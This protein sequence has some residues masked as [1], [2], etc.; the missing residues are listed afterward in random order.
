MMRQHKPDSKQQRQWTPRDL[1]VLTLLGQQ[2]AL[3]LDHV[4]RFLALFEGKAGVEQ[5]VN[6][7][8]ATHNL[9]EHLQH[10]GLIQL[11]QFG[12]NKSNWIWLT[13]EGMQVA[14]LSSAAKKRPARRI[15]PAL[16]AT[17]TVRLHLAEQ[18]P[19]SSWVS[20]QQLRSSDTAR[21]PHLTP[22]AVLETGRGERI[23]IHIMLRLTRTEEQIADHML[24]Q[25][26]QERDLEK[27]SYSALW[28]YAP[29]DV[30]KKLRAARASIAKSTTRETA[31][32]ICIFTYPLVR[33][34]VLYRGHKAPV[35]ALAWS[36]D[37]KWLASAGED[38]MLNVWDAVTGKERFH[39]TLPVNP[40]A[41]GWSC[42][43]AWIALGDKDGR[44]SFWEGTTGK[45][46]TVEIDDPLWIIGLA[47]S[48]LHNDVIASC[49]EQGILLMYDLRQNA[50][51]WK[52]H[53]YS[54]LK[55][56]AWSPDGTRLAI[57]GNDTCVR[58][59]DA[60]TGKHLQTYKKHNA[61][62]QALVW[63]PDSQ[64]IAST[65]HEPAI[66]IWDA[67]SGKRRRTIRSGLNTISVLAW[68]PDGTRLACAGSEPYVQ[69]WDIATGRLLMTY[70]DHSDEITALAW[71]PDSTMLASASS[72][73]TV[74]VY[75]VESS[76]R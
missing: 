32:N 13:K 59:I 51:Q 8:S 40:S 67:V 11:Q 68:S 61:A 55:A 25:L 41:I 42:N 33:R 57:G 65:S 35:L 2:R 36:H 7:K 20:R 48:P 60:A 29:A 15:L 44:L 16:Y 31:R 56:L 1:Y 5:S 70:A 64:W 10:A 46:H 22:T 72:D 58:L 62:V 17:N 45:S 3:S 53:R 18:E 47:W 76:L 38:Q 69:I 43:D 4:S 37:G 49:S 39:H 24:Q 19:E 21:K 54:G 75:Q 9:I 27:P 66:R 74:H 73:C 26:E 6:L 12:K 71:S 28:Y 34:Q 63:S 50:L 23:A 30:T 14:G 52:S